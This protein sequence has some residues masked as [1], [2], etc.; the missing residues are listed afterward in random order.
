MHTTSITVLKEHPKSSSKAKA[1]AVWRAGPLSSGSEVSFHWDK[2]G[3]KR[4]RP[5]QLQVA[6]R[7]FY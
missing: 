1:H 5:F 7:M 2:H 6:P 4:I 3:E